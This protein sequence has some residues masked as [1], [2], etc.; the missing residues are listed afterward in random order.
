MI[1]QF[2]GLIDLASQGGADAQFDLGSMYEIGYSIGLVPY[3][4]YGQALRWYHKAAEQG[5][6]EHQIDAISKIRPAAAL[7]ILT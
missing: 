7:C 2:F 1:S 5:D 6:A 4:S 3:Q